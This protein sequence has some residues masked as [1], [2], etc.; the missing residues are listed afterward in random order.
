MV[1]PKLTGTLL[2]GITR[3]TILTLAE[4]LGYDAVEERVSL[5]QWRAECDAGLMPEAFA[6]GTAAV[7]TPISTVVDRGHNWTI[8]DG[9]PGPVTLA[10]RTALTDLHHGLVPDPDGW[11]H[12]PAGPGHAGH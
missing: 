5:D 6:C 12:S 4:R 11:L 10:L 2:P 7:V 3:T 9:K 8:G 1:T